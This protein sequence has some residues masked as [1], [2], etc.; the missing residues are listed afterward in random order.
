MKPSNNKKKPTRAVIKRQS[1]EP[2]TIPPRTNHLL[3]IGID[4]YADSRIV[5]LKNAVRDAKDFKNL[6]LKKYQFEKENVTTLFNKAATRSNIL[7]TFNQLLN[8]LLEQDNLIFYYS[9]HG[10]LV[11]QGRRKRGYWVPT[12]AKIKDYSSYLSNNEI[13]TLFA[14][15]YA[16]HIVGIV[17]SCFSGSLFLINRGNAVEERLESLPSRWLLTAG[18]LEL[19]SD[20]SLGKNSPFATALLTHLKTNA[21]NSL[22]IADLINR[23]LKSVQF[24]SEKQTPRGEPLQNTGHHGG[25]FV[26]YKK[27]Y[28]PVIVSNEKGSED[29]LSKG[30]EIQEKEPARKEK[31]DPISPMPT[32]LEALKPYLKS[33]VATDL[34]QALQAFK[35]ILSKENSRGLND[36]TQQL[37][38]YNRAKKAAQMNLSSAEQLNRTF[39][40]VSY[41][42]TQ[43]IDGLEE[44]N[45]TLPDGKTPKIEYQNSKGE[46]VLLDLG[47][48]EQSGLKEQATL[49]VKKLNHLKK[50]RIIETDASQQF[51]YDL[52]IEEIEQQLEMVKTSL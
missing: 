22:W 21:D 42:L 25:Q 3:V 27:G 36:I 23:V 26:F 44:K 14:D 32:N 24:N 6:L 29:A 47:K 28:V 51:K 8:K 46:Q 10:E 33:V 18:R 1:V 13:T 9:G 2:T 20:G 34:E 16:H 38:R 19:V 50:A 39:A 40:Q 17:D 30:I 7:S 43:M 48:L 52:Q 12:D 11:Q 31:I 49:L 35:S 37:G 5:D 15:S 4:D 45:I 41:A